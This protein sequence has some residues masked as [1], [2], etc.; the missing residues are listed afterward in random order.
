MKNIL[1]INNGSGINP[2][3]SGGTTR[4]IELIKFLKKKNFNIEVI[5]TIGS[6]KLFKTENLNVKTILLKS[7]IFSHVEKN[8]Y[9]RVIS[10]FISLIDF[11]FK[12]KSLKKNYNIVYSASDYIFDILPALVIKI[13]S[14]KTLFFSVVHHQIKNP[15]RRKGNKFLNLLSFIL[16]K[17]SFFLINRYA[18]KVFLYDTEEGRSIAKKIKIRKIFMLNGIT[19]KIKKIR[20]NNKIYDLCFI[21]GLRESKGI[22]EFIY[23]AKK[24]KKKIKSLKVQIIG[25]GTVEM[26]KKIKS[27][28]DSNNF[29]YYPGLS[30]QAM[31][32][33]LA[34][35]KILLST[36]KEE[37]WGIVVLEAMGTSTIVVGKMLPAFK[38]FKKNGYFFNDDKKI[39]QK[40]INILKNL[41]KYKNKIKKSKKY[42][43]DFFWEKVLQIDYREFNF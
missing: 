18:D 20:N 3:P 17:F 34:K 1:F 36:S 10:N 11:F 15:F 43:F 4:L 41:S 12:I 9:D 5:T 42:S 26:Q 23:L 33:K 14:K 38:K 32:R 39:I 16:Q 13:I 27:I 25:K 37:G 2:G 30:N 31:L 21:G 29:N 6:K 19:D 35:S 7:S 40:I 28:S 24:I 8:V 22:F